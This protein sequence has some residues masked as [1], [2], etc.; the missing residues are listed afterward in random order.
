MSK[1]ILYI[2][3]TP[4]G[5]LE[6]ITLRTLRILKEVDL[7]AAE[8]TRRTIKL[9]NHYNIKKSLISY[10]EHNKEARGQLLIEKLNEGMSIGF[11]T[12]AGMP[13]ISDPGEDLIRLCIEED[14][15][16]IVLPG[17]TASITALVNSGLPT[18]KFVFEGFF[19]SKRK[20]RI[21]ELE[22]LKGEKRTMIIY[23]APH[24]LLSLLKDIYEVLGDRRIAISRELTK[25]YEETFRG[26]VSEGI[27]KF[28]FQEPKGEFVLIL[29]GAKI[30]EGDLFSD[31]SIKE[32]IELYIKEGLTKKEAIKKVAEIRGIPK[33]LVYKESLK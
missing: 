17:P 5:N 28:E 19:P 15:K 27:K 24:R 2:C 30:E 25:I 21:K 16:V 6:D 13:G 23:E 11:V 1:G 22:R 31:I 7:I 8:D 14:I 9:L 10:H 26:C 3:P 18:G 4:I 29:E 32:H 33:N 20:E 12:D